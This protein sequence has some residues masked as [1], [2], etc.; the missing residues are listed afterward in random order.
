M[1]PRPN[2]TTRT[3]RKAKS[4]F[5]WELD[6][7]AREVAFK[8]WGEKCIVSMRSECA[9]VLDPHHVIHRKNKSVHFLIENVV[10]LCRKHHSELDRP[11]MDKMF[12]NWFEWKYPERWEKIQAAARVISQLRGKPYIDFWYEYLL[13]EKGKLG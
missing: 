3:L 8:F 2:H 12:K 5:M 4:L 11:G 1:N 13:T 9:G 10:P 7:L 6:K